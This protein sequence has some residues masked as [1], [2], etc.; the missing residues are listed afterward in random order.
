MFSEY[1]SRFLA[2][3]QSR[4]LPQPDESR[5]KGYGRLMQQPGNFRYPSSRSFLQRGAL[6]PYQPAASQ[7]SNLPFTSRHLTQPAPLFYSA[8][9]EFYEEDEEAE[10]E[11]EIADFYALQKSR[12]NFGG[13]HMRDS[14]EIDEDDDKS[15]SIDE[16]G[17]SNSGIYNKRK[18]IKSSWRAQTSIQEGHDVT[19]E[20]MS[21]GDEFQDESLRDNDTVKHKGNLVD[22]RLEDSLHSAY[23]GDIMDSSEMGDDNPPSIQRF[24]EQPQLRKG[25]F[26]VDS[27]TMPAE[28]GRQP[29]VGSCRPPSADV[30]YQ[31][32]FAPMIAE[33]PAHDVFWGQLFLI[34]LVCL[35]ATS[36]LVYLHTSI[37]SNDRSRW[38][39]TVY[40]TMHSSFYL[41]GVYT[42]VSVCISMLWLALL[43]SYVR[44][45]IYAIIFV[46]PVVLCSFSLYPFV[47]SFRGA[48]HGT[49]IQDKVM[50]YGSIVPLII[51]SAWTYNVIRGR[52]A[53]GRAIGILEFACRVLAANPELL[54]IGLG[55]LAFVVSWTWMWMLMFT[56]VFLGGHVTG[57]KRFSIDLS[58]WWLGIYF[59]LIY[60]WSL[61]I[62]AGVQRAVTAATVSQWYFHRLSTPA[63]SSKRVVQAAIM[64]SIT[65]LFGTVCLSRLIALLVRLPLILLPSRVTSVLS[66]FAYSV[67][68]TPVTA[69]TDPLTLTYAAIHS[70]PLMM[71]TRS[72]SRMTT[73]STLINNS[74]LHPRSFSW[75]RDTMTSL[76]PYRL[77][78]LILHASRIMMSLALGFGGWVTAAR[79]L[80]V[81]SSGNGIPHGSVYAY[82]VG[83]TAG[84][85]GWTVLGAIESV[86]ADIVDA[87]VVC[88]SS[89]VGTYGREARYCRE[90]GWLFGESSRTD[91]GFTH[92]HEAP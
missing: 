1:A 3:S 51:A 79:D 39:D 64:H 24:R 16:Q 35:F 14:S 71:S 32:S 27:F 5:K 22:V 42:V 72:L 61:G 73:L 11:R 49:S 9:N 90:A 37:P 21:E 83:L 52:H 48:W 63:P 20:P 58:S 60:V 45:L 92:L 8:T 4:L 53:I 7:V 13:S 33:S 70:Q 76:L 40:L 31:A 44:Q 47:S 38:G 28:T 36:F 91:A 2:Q 62:I 18:G 54:F 65:T 43:R 15:T 19:V 55:I 74:S 87:S 6:D 17:T 41:L 29:L 85:I 77:S 46:V 86:I 80:S 84:T 67:V 89:E 34:S 26:G 57:S 50:R 66:L 12:R 88:W 23:G 75:S 78:K 81:S 30:P 56:R 68:P 82:V 10:H 25:N 69:L 59:T